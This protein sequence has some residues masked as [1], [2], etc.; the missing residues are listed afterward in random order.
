MVRGVTLWGVGFEKCGRQS[1]LW[2]DC[3]QGNHI[4]F[5]KTM[6]GAEIGWRW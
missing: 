5:Q 6:G 1:S 2:K 3:Q 4:I